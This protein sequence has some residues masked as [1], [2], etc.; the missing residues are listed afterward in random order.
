MPKRIRIAPIIISLEG[1]DRALVL[2]QL[3]QCERAA[4]LLRAAQDRSGQTFN[5][6]TARMS[7]IDKS[8]L[9]AGPA[10]VGADSS[11]MEAFVCDLNIEITDANLRDVVALFKAWYALVAPNKY[12]EP[13]KFDSMRETWQMPSF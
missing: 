12:H 13:R 10:F 9:S 6:L 3:T 7:V 11:D 4:I 1:E 5:R 2:A 8:T